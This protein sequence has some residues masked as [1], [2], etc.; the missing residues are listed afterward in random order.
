MT[1][2]RRLLY[3]ARWPLAVLAGTLVLTRLL[4]APGVQPADSGEFQLVARELG[5]AH[6]PGYALYTM[7]AHAW[8]RVAT[9]PA[10]GR[11]LGADP[12][13]WTAARP[14]DADPWT[15]AINAF[16]ALLAVLTLALVYRTG[17]R[18]T[19]A[20]VGGLAAALALV[21]TPTFLA[22]TAVANIRMPTALLTALLLFLTLHWLGMQRDRPAEAAR[23]SP[24]WWLAALAL[25]AGLA[26]GHHG[27]LVFV[28]AACAAV[29]LWSRPAAL[30]D[31]RTMATVAGALV[32]SF[33]PLLY[34]PIRD[35]QG[36]LFDEDRLTTIGGFVNHVSAA[37]FRGDALYFQDLTTALDRASVIGNVFVLQFGYV[38]L[39][40][41]TVGIVVL[42]LGRERLAGVLLAT[43]AGLTTLLTMTYRAPQTME[44]LLPAYVA[45][46]LTAGV[47]I[48]A[49]ARWRPRGAPIGRMAVAL[50]LV[51]TMGAAVLT[52]RAVRVATPDLS[53][54]LDPDWDSDFQTDF[55][56]D[57]TIL[58]SWHYYTPLR[59]LARHGLRTGSSTQERLRVEYVYP[60]GAETPGE[61]WLRRIRTTPGDVQITNRPREVGQAGLALWPIGHAPFFST[62]ERDSPFGRPYGVDEPDPSLGVFDDLV[63]MDRAMIDVSA[64]GSKAYATVRLHALR[65]ITETLTVTAQ[66]VDPATGAVWGQADHAIPPARWADERDVVDELTVVPFRGTRP[67]PPHVTVGLYRNTPRGPERL[68]IA[69]RDA[70]TIGE[71]LDWLQS[72]PAPRPGEVPFADAMSLTASA[73]RREGDQLIVDLTWRADRD[74]DA[75]DYTVSVQAHG[76]G[77]NAQDDGTPALGAIPT[78]KWLPGMVIHDRHRLQLPAGLPLDA[79]FHV[80]VGVYD[81]FSLEPLPVTDA[82]RVRQGQGQAAEVY[83]QGGQPG[84]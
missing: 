41:A 40:L 66:L 68:A 6:P 84:D 2:I 43:V 9:I 18:L 61:T 51:V 38:T 28:A 74:A 47:A 49:I 70:V 34:L 65:P 55:Q 69:G 4:T 7:T 58:A 50:W 5:I 54:L 79:P 30:R 64:D 80:T 21:A 19:G 24:D 39:A 20:R 71:A 44:Y 48:A 14:I 23:P 26:A 72:V 16:S 31:G 53:W 37:D 32:L 36:A 60:E 63:H 46:A 33:L 57:T 73:V 42:L 17:Y 78:L 27:S 3:R 35:L 59:Y 22:Q 81:A 12:A 83:R 82:E 45:M 77:W 29:V 76:D 10:V 13:L 56:D 52:T 15:W 8:G 1:P 75:S 11:A 25:V 62:S 67:A